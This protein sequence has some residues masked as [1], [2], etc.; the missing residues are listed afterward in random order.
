[1]SKLR[2]KIG[3]DEFSIGKQDKGVLHYTPNTATGNAV[4]EL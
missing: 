2:R 4:R 1:M 3:N